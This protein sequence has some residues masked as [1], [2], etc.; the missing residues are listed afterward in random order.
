MLASGTLRHLLWS[1]VILAEDI[2]ASNGENGDNL[3]YMYMYFIPSI[4]EKV[5]GKFS[6]TAYCIYSK[7]DT[8]HN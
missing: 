5:V 3:V 7:T 8:L 1:L 6:A 2:S 4:V